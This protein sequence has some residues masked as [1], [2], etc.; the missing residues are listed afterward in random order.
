MEK[1][2]S[3]TTLSDIAIEQWKTLCKQHE[4]LQNLL[5]F[6]KSERVNED[7]ELKRG[8]KKKIPKRNAHW[9]PTETKISRRQSFVDRCFVINLF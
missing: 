8:E 9:T 5:M 6:T 1:K 7:G 2:M 4:E 3:W